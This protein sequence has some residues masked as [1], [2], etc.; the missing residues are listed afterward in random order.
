[1]LVSFGIPGQS[2]RRTMAW[3]STGEIGKGDKLFII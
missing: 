2:H 3:L 1:M